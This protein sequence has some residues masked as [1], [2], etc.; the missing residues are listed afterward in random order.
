[1]TMQTDKK[2][3]GALWPV[4]LSVFLFSACVWCGWLIYAKHAEMT[5][6]A[7]AQKVKYQ[8]LQEEAEN[9]RKLLR[10][11]PCEAKEQYI[12]AISTIEENIAVH[13]KMPL[14]HNTGLDV[15][16]SSPSVADI[17]NV[18]VFIIGFPD[19][20]RLVTG[21]GF[22]IAPGYVLT[23]RHVVD[24]SDEIFVTSKALGQPAIGRVVAKSRN[25]GQDYALVSIDLPKNAHIAT[26]PFSSTV[27]RTEKVGAWG[28]PNIIGKNDPGYARLLKGKDFTAVPELSYTEGV[29]S[30]I[31]ERK[32][33][34]IIHTAPISPGNSGGPLLNANGQV[35]GINT[36]ISLDAS[37]FRQA[38]VALASADLLNFLKQ[39]GIDIQ[40]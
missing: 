10:L 26:L 18:C 13:K 4:L 38:S 2:E 39:N 20:N 19:N 25:R 27:S 7:E 28:Y 23:N 16:D 35:I 32:P 21:T 11:S 14:R 30:A 5:Q 17:E 33:P 22:F 40:E 1:M 31:L 29:V 34:V 24:K 9:L 15:P 12:K 37:S 6:E 36:M 3:S 8:K